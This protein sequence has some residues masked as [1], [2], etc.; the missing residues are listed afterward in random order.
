MASL[1][2]YKYQGAGNDFVLLDARTMTEMPTE[3]QIRRLCDRRFGV[4]GDGLMLLKNSDKADFEMCYYNSDGR[5][6]SMCG[7]GGRCITAFARKLGIVRDKARFVGYDGFHEAEIISQTENVAVVKL[8]MR[9]V[10]A[11]DSC[12]E[13]HFVDTGSPHYVEQ[14][15]EVWHYPVVEKGA[16]WRR[17]PH[18]PEGTNVDF[19]EISQ[20]TVCNAVAAT[21]SCRTVASVEAGGHT[22]CPVLLNVRTFERGVEDETYS[23]GTGVTASA[24]VHAHLHPEAASP[25]LIHTLGGDFQVFFHRSAQGFH[26]VWLQGP[27]TLVFE[28]E[29]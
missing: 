20:E 15:K 25:I 12:L 17:H 4:G 11:I 24:L 10:D 8:K 14:V 19:V 1:H 27:A 2:F 16:Y 29:I 13:G 3:E 28:G 22:T 26:D 9:D 7:N 18:F 23:C 21:N 6:G 5:L